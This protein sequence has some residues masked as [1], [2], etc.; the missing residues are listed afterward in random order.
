MRARARGTKAVALNLRPSKNGIITFLTKPRPAN[1]K[2]CKIM[3]TG[4]CAVC[5]KLPCSEESLRGIVRLFGM[6]STKDLGTMLDP[7]IAS[8]SLASS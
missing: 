3:S 4:I 7:T 6:L 2:E 5:I 1:C 8:G